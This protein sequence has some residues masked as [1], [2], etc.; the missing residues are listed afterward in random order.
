[1]YPVLVKNK[2]KRIGLEWLYSTRCPRCRNTAEVLSMTYM[3]IYEASKIPKREVLVIDDMEIPK[4]IV[5]GDDK[6]SQIALEIYK[7]IKAE[8][9]ISH[10][11]LIAKLNLDVRPEEITRAINDRLES[12]GFIKEVGETPIVIEFKCSNRDCP[13][14]RGVK[15][16]DKEDIDKLQRLNEITPFYFF[17]K[18]KLSYGSR[19][20]LTQRPGTESIDKLFTSRNKIALSVLGR[21]IK[22]LKVEKNIKDTLLLC[23]AA[24]L[25]H[26]CKMERPNKKGWGVKNYIVHPIFLE[27]NVLHVFKNRFNA[28]MKGK[29]E[30]NREIGD[31]FQE[32][33]NPGDLINDKANVC[34][35]NEDARNLPI[36]DCSVDYVF[37]DP[38]Y[39][40]SIQYYE[41]SQLGASW[42]GLENDWKNEIVVNPKQGKATDI[43][44]DML[45]EAFKEIYRVLKPD[46]YMTVTFHS[47]EIKYWNA[48]MYAIQVTGFRYVTAV[49]Q[50]PQREYTNW[51]Y[52]KNPGEMT[53][54]IYVTF[55]K[56][57]VKPLPHVKGININRIVS[58]IIL[59]KA[60]QIILLHN[61]Q[62]TF[63]QLVRG[64]TLSL[65]DKGLMHNSKVRDLNYIKIFDEHFERL[66]RRA[67]IWRLKREER[68]SPLDFVP[69]DRRIEWIAF[70]VFNK[71]RQQGENVTIDDI[72]SAIFT[73][74]KNSKT[75]E[76]REILQIIRDIAK[77]VRG[78]KRPFWEYMGERQLTL[79][80]FPID[81]YALKISSA[82][83]LDHSRVIRVVSQF[84]KDFGY[85]VWI[86]EPEIRKN[87]EL[88]KYRNMEKLVIP[89]LDKLILER[90]KNIDI[91]WLQR[92]AVP[93]S[94]IEVEHTTNLREG[95]LRM[96]NVFDA[97]PHLRI[98]TFVIL[99]DKRQKKLSE[100]LQ[101]PSIKTLLSKRVVYYAPYSLIAELMDER[102]YRHLS[103]DDFRSICNVLQPGLE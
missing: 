14:R 65:I 8:G 37:T 23:F 70:S 91:I 18:K 54:D 50:I 90:L 58:D 61:G 35:L 56:P 16:L 87:P 40:D 83:E 73:L 26:V 2:K 72:L 9:P 89:G 59:P 86:G 41:L 34:F 12:P 48:L 80:F 55:Y 67:K 68:V 84:G 66:T 78:E 64:I 63:N 75:P 62:A 69:L 99:P 21:E 45:C 102:E 31:F 43:Y 88:K 4:K 15:R 95:L 52:A 25:E 5:Q 22:N 46:K 71:K 82:E 24:I 11:E 27:Q 85:D 1:C 29:E 10:K 44:R 60:R 53:G 76:N 47:R 36:D 79:G 94:L 33:E 74:L 98:E 7:V 49:Y 77:P 38:E 103:F 28:I 19:R 81:T 6:M 39:G 20:F 51:I 96:A 92:K 100:V 42:L 57:K 30:A 3:R 13:M 32:S 93:V 17:P 101:E 97:I